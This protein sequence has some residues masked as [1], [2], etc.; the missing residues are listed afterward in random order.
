V[1]EHGKGPGSEGW[2]GFAEEASE[3]NLGPSSE[4]EEAMRE[5]EASHDARTAERTAQ[6]K[7]A[8]GSAPEELEAA[9]A[10]AQRELSE[11]KDR[12]L[13]LAADFENAR[14][15]G[16][17]EREEASLFGHQIVVKDLLP[18]VDNLE[19]AIDHA[20]E[21]GCAAP[22]PLGHQGGEGTREGLLEGVELVLREIVAVLARHGVVPIEAEG[23]PFDPAL[24]EAM[25]Q[26]PDGTVPANTVVQVFQPGYQLRGRLLRPAR[27]V[28][29]KS[30]ADAEKKSD[31]SS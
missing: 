1:S 15:R 4:L 25:A 28:V 31:E 14:R 5:A 9:L 11:L 18:S 20:R 13:R 26:L 12:H 8:S 21:A 16:L 17:R 19:R 29:S 7:G 2:E 10:D 23:Q 30:P 22:G 24:H 6:R 27:V 3:G